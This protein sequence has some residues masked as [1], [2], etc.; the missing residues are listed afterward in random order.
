[1]AVIAY[2]RKRKEKKKAIL[3]VG[4]LQRHQP[5]NLAAVEP[6]FPSYSWLLFALCMQGMKLVLTENH[7]YPFDPALE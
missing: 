5:N 1:M 2:L 4:R 7:V 3:L 6:C